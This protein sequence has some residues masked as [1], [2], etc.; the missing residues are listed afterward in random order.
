M[1]VTKQDSPEFRLA[2][3]IWKKEPISIEE[4]V[5]ICMSDLSWDEA[6]IQKEL[7]KLCKRRIFQIENEIVTS[8]ISYEEYWTKLKNY[9]EASKADALVGFVGASDRFYSGNDRKW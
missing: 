1:R 5:K 9:N 4:L 6:K 2:D 3:M 8:M 7:K